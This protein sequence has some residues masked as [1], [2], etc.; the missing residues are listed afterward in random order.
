MCNKKNEVGIDIK[1][2]D[3]LTPLACGFLVNE[4]IK[5]LVY[6]KSQ[7]PYP[8]NWLQT[9]VARKRKSME[10]HNPQTT[11]NL[12]VERHYKITSA[13]YD[14]V[15]EIMSNIKTEFKDSIQYIKEVLII[16]GATPYTPK[17]VFRINV[18]VLQ[19]NHIEANHIKS[20]QKS[21]QKIL[22][23]LFLSQDWLKAM[24]SNFPTTNMYVMLKKHQEDLQ[25]DESL[26]SLISNYNIPTNSN[27]VTINLDYTNETGH[28]CCSNIAVFNDSLNVG[29]KCP[30]IPSKSSDSKELWY[31]A[32]VYLKGFKDCYINKVS[33]TELF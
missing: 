10:S 33:A 3:V 20:M 25:K 6:Q 18:P 9:V 4:I 11:N 23:D 30:Q 17:E 21:Q 5:Y 16:F 13:A 24:E 7:I 22:R 1:I 8:Y 29:N 14:T 19:E 28:V 12:L 31:Q 27:C 15:E 2:T 32:K 26:F